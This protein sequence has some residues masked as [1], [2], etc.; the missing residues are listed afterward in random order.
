MFKYSLLVKQYSLG[1]EGYQYWNEVGSTRQGQ[2]MMFDKQPALLKSNIRNIED[3]SEKVLGY[4]TMSGVQ[5]IRGFAEEIPGLDDTP[6]PYYCLSVVR[7]PG[8]SRPTS[9]PAYFGRAT[10]DGTTVYAEVNHHCVDCREYR[11]SSALKPDYW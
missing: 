9:Y 3:E 5:E 4:F 1:P 7:G 2:G 11:G 8:S 6:N 10:Y